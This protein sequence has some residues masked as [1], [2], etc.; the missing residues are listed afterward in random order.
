MPGEFKYLA[1]MPGA[2]VG[3]KTYRVEIQE[4][5]SSKFLIMMSLR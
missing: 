5:L 4:E 3:D 1:L 2:G